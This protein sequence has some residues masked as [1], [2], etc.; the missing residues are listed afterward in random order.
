MKPS[1]LAKQL[2][3]MEDSISL[4]VDGLRNTL[5]NMFE[6]S[7]KDNEHS[8][9]EAA[10]HCTMVDHL[11]A[12]R[13]NSKWKKEFDDSKKSLDAKMEA[14]EIDSSGKPD[15]V[16]NLFESNVFRFTKRQNKDNT[17]TSTTDLVNALARLGVEKAVVDKALAMATKPRRGN[18]YYEVKTIEE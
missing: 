9:N 4:T 11:I 8:M 18:I 2:L 3:D 16:V 1:E 7:T 14:L 17:S 10:A 15:Q 5:D 13:M 6:A 12:S